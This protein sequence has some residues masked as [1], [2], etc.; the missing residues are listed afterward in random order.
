M[1]NFRRLHVWERAHQFALDVRIATESFPRSGYSELKAQLVRAA[2]SIPTNI[3][4]GCGASSR[5][6]FARYLDISIKST[7]EVEYQLQLAKDYSILLPNRWESLSSEVVQIRRM[8]YGLRKP[9]LT[10]DR[11]PA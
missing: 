5:K 3:V 7:F 11:N 1:Q 4:E 2:E 9:V 8:L 6:E 10:A